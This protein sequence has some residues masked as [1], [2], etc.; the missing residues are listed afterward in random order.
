MSGSPC[1]AAASAKAWLRG[2][3]RSMFIELGSHFTATAPARFAAA[4]ADSA[5]ARY[6]WIDAAHAKRSGCAAATAAA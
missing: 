2:A 6:G 1:A 4:S 5:S 3:R